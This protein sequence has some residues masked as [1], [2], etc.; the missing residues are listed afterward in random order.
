M[1]S[2]AEVGKSS[3]SVKSEV[4]RDIHIEKSITIN[5]AP[6]EV[7]RLWRDF[8]NLPRFMKGLKAVQPLGANRYHWI[9]KGP[10]EANYEWD[11]EI[12]NEKENELIA[13][14]SLDDADVPNA[15]SVRFEKAP[16]DRGTYVYVTINYNPTGGRLGAMWGKLF[17]NE[18]E[19]LIEENLRRLK[20]VLETGE[21]ATIEGQSSGRREDQEPSAE[22]KE[23]ITANKASDESRDPR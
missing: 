11:A 3:T 12:Y 22:L 2:K 16:G 9:A 7:Y 15:G 4:P 5:V 14:R 23:N 13:W 1:S 21:I 8:E 6:E 19:Q 20:Q 10:T 17:G 18:P